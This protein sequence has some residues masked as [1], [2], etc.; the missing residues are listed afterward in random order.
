M[1]IELIVD[2]PVL[3]GEKGDK[4]D[5]GSFDYTH[6]EEIVDEHLDNRF[7]D[8]EASLD[9]K[10]D[11]EVGKS[12]VDDDY[13]AKLN[14]LETLDKTVVEKFNDKVEQSDLEENLIQIEGQL[15]N[16]IDEQLVT[17]GSG[18][19]LKSV[20]DTDGDGV[21][22]IAENAN[23]SDK[24]NNLTVETAV[25]PDA[26]F[27]DTT[28]ETVTTETNGLM[29]SVDKIKLNGIENG[30]NNT[31][32]INNLTSTEIDKALSAAQGK[33]INDTITSVKEEVLNIQNNITELK[34]I[35]RTLLFQGS[36]DKGKLNLNDNA[37]NY[38]ELLIAYSSASDALNYD[39]WSR[40]LIFPENKPSTT[41]N[42]I[43]ISSF[44][45]NQT[46]NT[47]VTV[48]GRIIID[49]NTIEIFYPIKAIKH[50]TQGEKGHGQPNTAGY[51]IRQVWG[52]R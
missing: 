50:Y 26:V 16:Y 15:Q 1:A 40:V 30:A 22:D 33:N 6:L 24:V 48:I 28:Y 10:V 12:L 29:S 35:K 23:N 31:E 2:T 18:D 20:Y 39:N 43:I 8:V 17:T 44:E 13:I 32:I 7:S 21:V 27:T 25:P 45:N 5:T 34:K 11:K 38:S 3:K 46:G 52:V 49:G 14:N 42:S 41:S 47:H 4:G 36:V 51:Y 37:E 19:M 9:L